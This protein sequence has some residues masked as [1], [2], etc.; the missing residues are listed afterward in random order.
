MQEALGFLLEHGYWFLGVWVLLDQAGVPIPAL[1]VLI[2]AGALAGAGEMDL[3]LAIGVSSAASLPSDLLWFQLGRR[4]GIGVLRLLCRL[5]VEP[6]SCVR[7]SADLFSRWGARTLLLSK[8]VPGLQVAAP[9]LAGVFRLSLLRFLLLDAAGALLWSTAFIGLGFAVQ[10]E[11]E[12][13]C[14]LALELGG[15]LFAILGLLFAS[16]LAVK[17]LHRQRLLRELRG[18]RI[19][20]EELMRRLEAGEQIEIVGLRH[21][22]D[23]AAHPVTLPGARRIDPAELSELYAEIPR[24]RELVLYCT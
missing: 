24:G 4:R 15:L 14:E 11:L 5:A 17:L 9:P 1:P 20:P 8:F 23:F 3:G 10:S 7:S 2:G 16:Y 21:A 19:T 6:D 12:R 13:F 22:L 18:A